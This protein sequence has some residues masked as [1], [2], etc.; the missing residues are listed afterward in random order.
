MIKKKSMQDKTQENKK[1]NGSNTPWVLVTGFLLVLIVLLI[2]EV[3][4]ESKYDKME[5]YLLNYYYST[6]NI[7]SA[8]REQLGEEVDE[9]DSAIQFV[10][11]NLDNYIFDLVLEDINKYENEHL[12]K[13]NTYWKKSRADEIL[14]ILGNRESVEMDV[15]E[16]ICY[17]K[18]PRFIKK[19]TYS[20]LLQYEEVLKNQRKFIIDLRDNAGGNIDE[21]IDV[22][23]LFYDKNSVVYTNITSEK[24]MEFKTKNDPMIDFDK[25]IF[26]CNE[27]TASSSEVMI[28]NMKEDFGNKIETVGCQTYGKNFCYSYDV[29]DDGE[30]FMFV[31]GLMGT[32]EGITFD[33]EGIVPDHQVKSE[34]ALETAK[35][36]LDTNND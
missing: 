1:G 23:S 2:R 33:E 13:Y 15:F 12:A 20:E 16:D 32:A 19:Q 28:F 30:M 8:I 7:E 34:F 35:Q 31:T 22:L 4:D 14:N 25:I 21:L 27:K 11:Q 29:F 18:I 24:N 6:D 36:L 26:L 17:I 9:S 10:S 5:N 3:L